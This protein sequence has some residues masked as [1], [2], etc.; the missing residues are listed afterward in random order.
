MIEATYDYVIAGAG[1]AGCVLA[2]RLSENPK[3][4]VLLLEAGHEGKGLIYDMPAGSFLLMGNPK[5][6]W[7]Y[8]TEPDASAEGRS[9]LWTGG[10]VQGGSSGINGMVYVRGQRNDY[11][12]WQQNGCPGWGWDDLYPYFLKAEDFTGPA[13]P[14]HRKGGPLTV[15]PQRIVHPL[16]EA[17]IRAS[18]E[19]GMAPRT[20]YCA[21]EQ[22][23]AFLVFSTIRD[24]QRCSTRKAYLDPVY[25]RPNLTVISHCLVDKVIIRNG[26]AAG[27]SARVNGEHREFIASAEV[28]LSGGTIATP[29][30]LL[31]SGIGPGAE[32]QAMGIA[33]QKD[34]PGVGRNLQEHVGV[35]QSRRVD[36]PTYN[37]MAV[38]WQ[39]PFHLLRYL[40]T[41]QGIMTSIAA[42]AMAYWRSAPEQAE[43]DMCMSFMPLA[44]MFQNGKPRFAKQPGV[45]I[46][47]QLTRPNG[48][49]RIRLKSP[50]PATVPIIDH[51]M[52]GHSRD[53]EL[54][55][56]GLRKV[57][58]LFAAPALAA[59]V[60][61][62]L[63][64]ET[65]PTTDA[66]W[67]Q[68]ARERAGIGYHPVGS[69]RM[70]GDEL[71]VV[72]PALQVHGVRRLR[73]VDASVFPNIIS[74]NTNA[75][76]IA[77]AEKA[78]DIIQAA[79]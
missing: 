42:Q 55:L 4:R 14:A 36:V 33:V 75:P 12:L 74:G 35:T 34:L 51:V 69:C 31:R 59:H 63:E 15:S 62:T 78:A 18:G 32:L 25:N 13:S 60:R 5:A 9:T 27:V 3:N 64:P 28:I 76:T 40:A 17:F 73:I 77:L 50:D 70:G 43:A 67:E 10:R 47:A 11:E 52:L 41:K 61:G 24:G 46:G 79:A 65:L 72:D 21:G 54:T 16:A 19:I 56:H 39:L 48:R 23:G 38:P 68:L 2:A 45:T 49:G 66:Q 26:A 1:S 57:A 71:A 44:I 8:P 20:E 7:L 22:D 6:A 53:L 29:A 58:D 37:S 30:I